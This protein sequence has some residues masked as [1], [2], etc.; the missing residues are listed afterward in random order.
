LKPKNKN[1][2]VIHDRETGEAQGVY[3]RSCHD[4]YEFSSAE[5]ARSSNCHDIYLD[6]NKYRIGKYRVTY[7]LIDEDAPADNELDVKP[8]V[9]ERTFIMEQLGLVSQDVNPE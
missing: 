7:E 4:D 3:S 1:V 2:F 6:K 8:F 5:R 9:D